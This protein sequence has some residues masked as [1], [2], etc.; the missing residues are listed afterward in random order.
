MTA[1]LATITFLAHDYD[2]TRAW[3]N[4]T[5]GFI[6]LEDTALGDGKRW[7]RMAPPPG[8]VGCTLLIAKAVNAQQRSA[9]GNQGGGRVMFFLETAHFDQHLMRMRRHGVVLEG[10]PRTEPYGRVIVFHDLYGN[11]WDLIEPARWSIRR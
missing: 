9:V 4:R 5:M 7:L 1:R 8:D 10:S 3:F 6:T 11:R 2:E